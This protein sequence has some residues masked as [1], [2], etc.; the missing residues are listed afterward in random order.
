MYSLCLNEF[1]RSKYN[2][3]FK[4]KKLRKK[5][6]TKEIFYFLFGGITAFF[7]DFSLLAIQVYVLD[8]H[9]M[10]FG[11]ISIPN[12][13][14]SVTAIIYN[15]FIQ[16][17]FAFD[18]RGSGTKWELTRFILVQV[19]TVVVFAGVVFGSLL[20]MGLEVPI[21]KILTMIL[22]MISSFFLYKF[23]VFRK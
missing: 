7:I 6:F 8:F 21:A 12:I 3:K 19:F 10:L 11:V 16:K 4:N 22:Q 15:F 2:T 23:F 17:F 13:I 9:P 14:S 1:L 20:N 5:L 18:S